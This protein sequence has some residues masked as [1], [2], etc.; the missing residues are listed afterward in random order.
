MDLAGVDFHTFNVFLKKLELDFERCKLSKKNHLLVF[1]MKIKTSLTYSALGV[2]FKVDRTTVERIFIQILE[3][4][5]S[6]LRNSIK[7]YDR[8][9]VYAMVPD[10]FKPKYADVR[11]IIDYT[12]FPI[13]VPAHIDQRILIIKKDSR[14]KC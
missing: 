4:L 11:V 8:D 14:L 7:W 13:E 12:E 9:T 2:L 1:F 6:A 5:Y 10:C 3:Y